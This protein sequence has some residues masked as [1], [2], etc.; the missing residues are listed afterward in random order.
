MKR[1][2]S[3]ILL[4][5]IICSVVIYY[6][7]DIWPA[8]PCSKPISFSIGVF[9]STFNITREKFIVDTKLASQAWSK[10]YGQDLF[11]YDDTS[12]LKI[13][14]IYDYRQKATDELKL[15]GIVIDSS[16]AT[17]DDLK[18]KYDLLTSTYE[19][20]KLEY[21]NHLAE[22]NNQVGRINKRGGATPKER[23]TL[24]TEKNNLQLEMENLNSLISQIN[25]LVPIL[26]E[27]AKK[28]NISVEN[29]NRIGA[30]T[31]EEFNEGEYI[32]NGNDP[33]INIYQFEDNNQLIRVLEHE[34]GHALGLNHVDDSQAIM[35]RL[36]SSLNENLTLADISE[37][38]RVCSQRQ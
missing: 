5:V 15:Q 3:L 30:S 37:L 27:V 23:A 8:P 16:K 29:F 14:L 13:N 35:Y 19:N 31:G 9:D 25:S 33:Y 4:L 22:Y 20:K 18:N 34:F 26:N 38:Q 7:G 11:I 6:R 21:E 28:L 1:R 32:F 36:N 10:I 17:Y 24:E 12:K 2:S